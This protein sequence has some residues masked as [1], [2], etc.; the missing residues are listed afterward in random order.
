MIRG[1]RIPAPNPADP[2]RVDGDFCQVCAAHDGQPHAT[3]C[4]VR[5]D[6]HLLRNEKPRRRTVEH[7]VNSL[8]YLD[9]V[10]LSEVTDVEVG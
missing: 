5:A 3:W 1:P 8:L 4:S 6:A 7:Y 10:L 2:D 9:G